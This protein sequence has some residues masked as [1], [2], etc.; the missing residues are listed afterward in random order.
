MGKGDGEKASPVGEAD[1]PLFLRIV[2]PMYL[3]LSS[4]PCC[5]KITCSGSTGTEFHLDPR[6][7]D[8]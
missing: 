6:G 2:S 8:K 4:R 3:T 7:L 1:D 5:L